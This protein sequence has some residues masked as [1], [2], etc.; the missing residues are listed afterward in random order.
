MIERM[1]SMLPAMLALL[2]LPAGVRATAV[3]WTDLADLVL[4]SP[5]VLVVE[6][7]DVS[8]LSSR[9]AP[10]VPVGQVR[11]LVE[12]RLQAALRAPGL[13]PAR[14]EWL[15]QGT[16]DARRR[17]PFGKTS[18]QL[19]FASPVTGGPSPDVQQLRLVSPH[20]QQP[21]SIGTEAAVRELLLA[22]RDPAAAMMVT[23][24][25]DAQ[26]GTGTVAGAGESQFFLTTDSGRPL[27]LMVA[28]QPGA[29]PR[30]T[31]A[32]GELTGGARAVEPRTLLWRA[33]A[34]GLPESLPGRLD[35]QPALMADLATARAAIGPCGRTVTP[36]AR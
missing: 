32:T 6:V 2:L 24:I 14:A 20:G 15:W 35:A 26:H 4:A 29:D 22:A 17:P 27:V 25:A 19:L 36:P 9:A 34:C 18:R 31:V 7:T 5:A 8:R 21:W 33:L 12:G 3:S 13:L 23:G 30:V 16:P 11:A 1:L 28:R 10:D